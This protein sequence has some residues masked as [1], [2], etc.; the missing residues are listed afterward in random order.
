MKVKPT[1][2]LIPLPSRHLLPLSR[3]LVPQPSLRLQLPTLIRPLNVPN[4]PLNRLYP[5]Y[6]NLNCPMVMAKLEPNPLLLV[7][8]LLNPLRLP[9]PLKRILELIPSL[10]LLQVKGKRFE[11]FWLG[12]SEYDRRTLV[13][14]EKEAVLRKMKE[15]QRHGCSCAVCGRKR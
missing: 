8:F 14:I 2:L 11:I 12:L 3:P 7:M 15:Q 13:R 5:S 4:L 10:Q 1:F 9:F 6:P